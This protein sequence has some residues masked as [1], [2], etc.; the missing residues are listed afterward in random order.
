MYALVLFEITQNNSF[1]LIKP[2][3]KSNSNTRFLFC[4]FG[5][6][7][8]TN[9]QHSFSQKRYVIIKFTTA[10]RYE[11]ILELGHFLLFV[12]FQTKQFDTKLENILIA[13]YKKRLLNN[14]ATKNNHFL[15]DLTG[16]KK[17]EISYCFLSIKV[18]TFL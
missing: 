9:S 1:G 17:F 3:L 11:S 16:S 18:S 5:Q 4:A 8:C 2:C 15:D 13:T 14:L 6:I 7:Y 12:S 10:N